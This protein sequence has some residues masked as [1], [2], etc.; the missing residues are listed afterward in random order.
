MNDKVE[1]LKKVKRQIEQCNI[2]KDG[3]FVKL[4]ALRKQEKKLSH[5]VEPLTVSDHAVI[6]YYERVLGISVDH[7]REKIL[8]DVAPLKETLGVRFKAPL[9]GGGTAVVKDNKVVTIVD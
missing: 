3:I 6:R 2:E 4:K 1:E 9:E 8:R 5:D 7:V